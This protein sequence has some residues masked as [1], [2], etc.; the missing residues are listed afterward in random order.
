MN[1]TFSLFAIILIP[2]TIFSQPP[3]KKEI[4]GSK[5]NNREAIN[6]YLKNTDLS[7][8]FIKSYIK[9]ISGHRD[10]IKA[11]KLIKQLYNFNETVFYRFIRVRLEWE[12]KEHLML[13]PLDS[14]KPL[15]KN[16]I[17]S[18]GYY[19][20]LAI[21]FKDSMYER[22]ARRFGYVKAINPVEEI[23]DWAKMKT[24]KWTATKIIEQSHPGLL[25]S[26]SFR[27]DRMLDSSVFYYKK[28]MGYDPGEFF[29]LADL[30]FY[31][32]NFG[33]ESAL[34]QIIT[35][36]LNNYTGKKKAWLEAY[37]AGSYT[38]Q[39]KIKDSQYHD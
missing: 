16:K 32:S 21:Y 11:N 20:M 15:L 13:A 30:L 10:H 24:I 39:K 23:V 4:Y 22:I 9:L 12:F 26:S 1:F 18:A 6:Y 5:E 37:L 35:S 3:I 8:S 33:E 38:R 27:N 34:Q 36:K 31:L 25:L 19:Y 2:A 28:A 14:V 7:R 29:Y 17:D